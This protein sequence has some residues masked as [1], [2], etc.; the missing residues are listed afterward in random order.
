MPISE[1]KFTCMRHSAYFDSVRIMYI[2]DMY[3]LMGEYG[4]PARPINY[5]V[6]YRG[7]MCVILCW[8]M[9]RLIPCASIQ[10]SGFQIHVT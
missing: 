2:C 5:H 8:L 1:Y 9:R 6:Y 7:C 4:I 10:I 3:L